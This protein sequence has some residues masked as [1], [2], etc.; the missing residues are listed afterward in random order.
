MLVSGPQ[1]D[2]IVRAFSHESSFDLACNEKLPFFTSEMHKIFTHSIVERLVKPFLIDWINNKD[3][4]FG[5]VLYRQL[6]G[7]LMVDQLA[8]PTF[9]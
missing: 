2:L 1:L 7:I 3:I 4:R 5:T 6:V 9:R 8:K